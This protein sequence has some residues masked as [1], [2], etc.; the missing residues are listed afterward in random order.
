[1][2]EAGLAERTGVLLPQPV[3][4]AL[5]VV[6]VSAGQ[7][8]YYLFPLEVVLT[9]G[10]LLLA[11]LYPPVGQ[12]LDLLLREAPGDLA[13]LLPQLQ[14]LL[15]GHV[16]GVGEVVGVV[17]QLVIMTNDELLDGLGHVPSHC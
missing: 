12:Q 2:H 6:V 1:M 14:Q 7:V 16:V 10:A 3:E 9:Y 15:V 13:D 8:Y 5:L 11:L 4:N 17:M